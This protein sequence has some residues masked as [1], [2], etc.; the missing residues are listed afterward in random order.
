MVRAYNQASKAEKS[1]DVSREFDVT[2]TSSIGA[3]PQEESKKP[4]EEAKSEKPARR[5]KMAVL[6]SKGRASKSISGE[7]MTSNRDEAPHEEMVIEKMPASPF[8]ALKSPGNTAMDREALRVKAVELGNAFG[9]VQEAF[10]QAEAAYLEESHRI[11]QQLSDKNYSPEMFLYLRNVLLKKSGVEA[12]FDDTM[13]RL[14]N[15]REAYE[16]SYDTWEKSVLAE[17]GARAAMEKAVDDLTAPEEPFN[18]QEQAWFKK[19]EEEERQIAAAREEISHVSHEPII[20]TP[21]EIEAN[22]KE[23]R[24]MIARGEL[25]PKEFDLNDYTYLLNEKVQLDSDLEVAG[26]WKARELRKKLKE[27]ATGGQQ[28]RGLDYYERQIRDVHRE[29][30]Y[31]RDQAAKAAIPEQKP[32]MAP[33]PQEVEPKKKRGFFARLFGR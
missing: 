29:R 21:G 3:L 22:V 8:E 15:A 9:N 19:G 12:R 24:E 16:K 2:E 28:M 31:E 4:A 14:V 27:N 11:D 5:A 10:D 18:E 25:D 13:M 26:W 6:S 20:E 33:E 1:K 7:F 23:A 17:A 32:A 30:G